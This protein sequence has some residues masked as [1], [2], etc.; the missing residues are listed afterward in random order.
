M[1]CNLESKM[2][3]IAILLLCLVL[4]GAVMACEKCREDIEAYGITTKEVH[5]QGL[6]AGAFFRRIS[7]YP[8]LV[9]V[10]KQ[11]YQMGLD[12]S[13]IECRIFLKEEQ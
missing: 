10:W 12:M 6:R 13:S 9:D 7:F 2:K 8:E 1:V 5:L 11:A 4:G 3:L